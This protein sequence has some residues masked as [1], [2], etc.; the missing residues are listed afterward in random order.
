MKNKLIVFFLLL[1]QIVSA[2][3]TN[4]VERKIH[5]VTDKQKKDKVFTCNNIPKKDFTI[6]EYEVKLV[7]NNGISQ[8]EYNVHKNNILVARINVYEST[9]VQIRA[10]RNTNSFTKAVEE[11]EKNGNALVTLTGIAWQKEIEPYIREKNGIT[12]TY[13]LWYKGSYYVIDEKNA[14]TIANR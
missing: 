5:T 10:I 7:E 2:Q 11:L 1:A 12:N 3:E 9:I 8:Y 14:I 4:K 6:G 13:T